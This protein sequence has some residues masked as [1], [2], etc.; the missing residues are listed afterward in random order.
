[1]RARNIGNGWYR[2]NSRCLLFLKNLS[3]SG[4]VDCVLF[5]ATSPCLVARWRRCR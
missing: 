5:S 2:V 4:G 1:L 3:V